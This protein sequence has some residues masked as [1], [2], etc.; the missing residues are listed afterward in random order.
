V[1]ELETDRTGEDGEDDIDEEDD[2]G[3]EERS[4]R[5]GEGRGTSSSEEE[6]IIFS[7]D[8]AVRVHSGDMVELEK[9]IC[10]CFD[11]RQKVDQVTL[12]NIPASQQN[13]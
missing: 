3:D 9:I 6:S 13:G 4:R 11:R 1:G 8:F 5:V 10:E 7:A 12:E 2:A